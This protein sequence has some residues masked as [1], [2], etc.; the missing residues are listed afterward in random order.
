MRA[1]PYVQR[2]KMGV[3]SIGRLTASTLL[4]LVVVPVAYTLVDDADSLARRAARAAAGRLGLRRANDP[5]T[6]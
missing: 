3:V 1:I 6:G 5:A 4:T 2:P